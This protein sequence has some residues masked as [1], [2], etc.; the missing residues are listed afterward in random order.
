[1]QIGR[2][3]E[4]LAM[5]HRV[6]VWTTVVLMSR[7]RVP[8]TLPERIEDRLGGV[9]LVCWPRYVKL[10]EQD[11]GVVLAP[12]AAGVLPRVGGMNASAEQWQEVL[13]RITRVEDREQERQLYTEL[14]VW[15]SIN[16]YEDRIREVARRMTADMKELALQGIRVMFQDELQADRR[17]VLREAHSRPRGKTWH[18]W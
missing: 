5:S 9:M 16:Y 12:G 15:C 2:R 8:L 4:L 6:P 11:A 17:E 7:R 10:W 13:A 14:S 3:A 1:M 18:S